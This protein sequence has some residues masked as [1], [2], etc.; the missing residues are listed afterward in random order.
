MIEQLTHIIQSN[1]PVYAYIFLFFAAYLENIFPPAPADMVVVFGAYFVGKGIL[2]FAGVLI[3]TTFGSFLGFMTL[4]SLAYIF[5]LQILEK[6]AFRWV[7]QTS[8]QRVQKWFQKYGLWIV[9]LNR[10]LSGLRSVISL[11]AGFS[12][13]EWKKVAFFSFLSALFW[14][15][16]LVYIGYLLGENWEKVGKYLKTYSLF[17]IFTAVIWIVFRWYR[18][19]RNM[20]G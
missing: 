14:N 12:R 18:K 13:L 10:F 5:E 1:H 11:V 2:G 17:I 19:R 3:S 6:K 8:V 16:I 4:Y 7:N 15:T 20:N 9:L